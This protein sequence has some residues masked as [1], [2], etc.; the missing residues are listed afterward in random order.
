[1]PAIPSSR[2]P[3]D[4]PGTDGLQKKFKAAL[5]T[6]VN[7]PTFDTSK[8]RGPLIPLPYQNVQAPVNTSIAY[9][10]LG[11][12]I[13]AINAS[14]AEGYR[15]AGPN[16]TMDP[17]ANIGAPEEVGPGLIRYNTASGDNVIVSQD[18]TPALYDQV[19]RLYVGTTGAAGA[20]DTS[21]FGVCGA[22]DLD[23]ITGN[24]SGTPTKALDL[25]RPR[26][27]AQLL[28][29]NWDAWGLHGAP[30]CFPRLKVQ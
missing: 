24:T 7:Q 23:T 17:A 4:T 27:A 20:S 1:M 25:K 6:S 3:V 28:S 9:T 15:L 5:F 13:F 21:S 8:I 16:D 29:Q 12:E 10:P 14:Q 2:D 19:A 11:S 26:A 22:R 18:I 30:G